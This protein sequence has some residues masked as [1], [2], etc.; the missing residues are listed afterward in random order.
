MDRLVA[1]G[2]LARP[3]VGSP[4]RNLQDGLFRLLAELR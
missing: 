2:F 3:A 1:A 4:Q